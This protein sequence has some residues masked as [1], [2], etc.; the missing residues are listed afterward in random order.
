MNFKNI[1]GQIA[2]WLKTLASYDFQRSGLVHSNADALSRRTRLDEN[3]K[4]CDKID[5]TCTDQDPG[6][7]TSVVDKPRFY[8]YA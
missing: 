2:W 8:C 7:A 6:L 5:S 3:C 4:Y 1:E